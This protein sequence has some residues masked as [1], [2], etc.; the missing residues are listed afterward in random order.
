MVY[1]MLRQMNNVILS[2]ILQ[3]TF[4]KNMLYAMK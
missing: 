2:M 4:M 3:S 1:Q